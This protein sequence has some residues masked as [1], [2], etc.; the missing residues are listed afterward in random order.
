MCQYQIRDEEPS[1]WC[2]IPT[3]NKS[4]VFDVDESN[5]N[6]HTII[7]PLNAAPHFWTMA[8]QSTDPIIIPKQKLP[9]PHISE[10]TLIHLDVRVHNIGNSSTW[11]I[12]HFAYAQVSLQIHL[13]MET[14]FHVSVHVCIRYLE[15]DDSA[16]NIVNQ[17]HTPTFKKRMPKSKQLIE[18]L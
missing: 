7:K 2:E 5:L 4:C 6:N 15:E 9:A 14:R 11:T 17:T 18:Q 10:R 13:N 8:N 1:L 3:R 12:S 16:P